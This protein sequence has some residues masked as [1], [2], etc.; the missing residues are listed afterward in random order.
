[1]N[2][3]AAVPVWVYFIVLAVTFVVIHLLA[4]RAGQ[5]PNRLRSVL[6]RVGSSLIL[7]VALILINPAEPV[8]LLLSLLL[9]ALAGFVSGRTATP[10]LPPSGGGSGG[11]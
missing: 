11:P 8:S 10:Q 5:A 1:M 3:L 7:L 2:V 4:L 9:A 6:G